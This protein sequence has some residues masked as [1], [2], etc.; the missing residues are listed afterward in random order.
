MPTIYQKVK[1]VYPNPIGFEKKDAEKIVQEFN[2]HLAITYVLYFQV[3]KHHWLVRGPQWHDIHLLLDEVAAELLLQADFFAERI[4]YFG[5]IPIS[6]MSEFEKNSPVK[7]EVDGLMDLK[8][9]LANDIIGTV[10]SLKRLRRTHEVTDSINDYFDTS[11]IEVYIG[12]REKFCHEI[13][14]YIQP[15]VLAADS[16]DPH[17]DVLLA[18]PK[19]EAKI[20]SNHL[21]GARS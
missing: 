10:E 13:H 11:Q 14:F 5:G 8:E 18:D 16:G 1:E 2:E 15:D 12:Q 7:P 6:S 3:K 9:M 21:T 19:L 4:T 17:Q 20:Q